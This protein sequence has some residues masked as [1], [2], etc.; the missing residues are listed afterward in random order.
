MKKRMGLMLA[1]AVMAVAVGLSGCSGDGKGQGGAGQPQAG[2]NQADQSPAADEQDAKNAED[3]QKAEEPGQEGSDLLAQIQ[4]KGE[5]VVAMEGTWSPWTYHDES[6]KLVGYDV[7]VAQLIANKLG[8]KAT[9]VEGEWDGLFAGLDAGRYDLVVNGVEVTQE[10]QE[11]YDF[12]DP[13]GYIRTAIIVDG[14]NMEIQSFEDL[15]GKKTANT[16]S[17]TYAELAESY[18]AQVTAVDDLNQTF[19]LLNTGRIDATLNA[20]LT[21][22]DYINAHPEK[23]LKIAALT[24]DASLVCI[25]IRKGVES[26]SL[27]KAVNKAIDEIRESGEL[28]KLSDKYFGNDISQEAGK[29][30]NH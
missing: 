27:R 8:V 19:E 25:P 23:N 29:V 2:G 22:Y 21:F 30:R 26:E 4:Q 5:L 15:N 14:S 11:K 16:I 18:G 24:D 17:S 3:S 20:E 6:D 9:F 12:S 7:E 10:R 1:A 13:Y 28:A